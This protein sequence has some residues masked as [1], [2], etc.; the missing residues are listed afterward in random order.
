MDAAT[1]IAIIVFAGIF[2]QWLAWRLRLPSI[3][4]LLIFGF[5]VGPL[6]GWVDSG[7][8][9]GEL[10]FPIVSLFVCVILFEGGL[11]LKFS[12]LKDV[13]KVVRN[14]AT[15]GVAVTWAGSAAAAYWFLELPFSQALLF[16]GI[17]TVTG[18]T[19]I[20]PMLRHVR[21]NGRVGSILKW[22]GIVNDPIGALL[23][24]LVFEAIVI[25][26][27][28]TSLLVFV[29]TIKTLGFGIGFGLLGAGLL[30][31][32]LERHS[33]P[34]FLHSPVA[35]ALAVAAFGASNSL[36]HESGLFAVTIM[37]IALANQ[38]RVDVSHIVEFKENLGVLMISLLFVMLAS[39]LQVDSLRF[40]S[41]KTLCF[42]GI[43]IFLIRP[44]CIFLS[45]IGSSL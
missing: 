25:E 27:S 42:L 34:D 26:S 29:G 4:L 30:Y 19:V 12:E 40:V 3:L 32:L 2:A 28:S 13:G 5:A 37:G 17:L 8:V 44:A 7:A 21:P 9:F 41:P 20:G 38:K 31:L 14:L 11:S 1:A 15:I 45:T 10:L 16:G 33:V 22:E 18:P 35:L 23:S 24:V 39:R 36:Q 6:T 43:L